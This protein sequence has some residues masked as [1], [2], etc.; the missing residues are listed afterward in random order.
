MMTK[1]NICRNGLEK[2]SIKGKM[3][4]EVMEISNCPSPNP[5]ITAENLYS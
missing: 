1:I 4:I 5:E 3:H 2:S